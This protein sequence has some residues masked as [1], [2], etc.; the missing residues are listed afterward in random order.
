MSSE[1]NAKVQALAT[2]SLKLGEKI[3]ADAQPEAGQPSDCSASAQGAGNGKTDE[4]VADVDFKEAN[5][6]R[7]N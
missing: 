5:T 6:R 3:Y 7:Q 2:A 1:I 4:D